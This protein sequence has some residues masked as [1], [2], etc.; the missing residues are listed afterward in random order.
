MGRAEPTGWS[1]RE[2]ASCLG[3]KSNVSGGGPPA[4]TTALAAMKGLSP[5]LLSLL[6]QCLL[7]LVT[8]CV[9]DGGRTAII[10]AV[11]CTLWNLALIGDWAVSKV[12]GL[13]REPIME[14]SPAWALLLA[15]AF[16]SLLAGWAFTYITSRYGR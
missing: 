16:L 13:R 5:F 1:E 15:P 10:W 14:I 3:N 4:L 2:P 12:R 9:L 7:L 6:G 8:M 11:G